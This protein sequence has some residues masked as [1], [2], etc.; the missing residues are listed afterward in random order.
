MIL[1][2]P[3]PS[4]LDCFISQRRQFGTVFNNEVQGSFVAV[5]AGELQLSQSCMRKSMTIAIDCLDC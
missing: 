4:N 2:Q 3:R 1:H 5:D